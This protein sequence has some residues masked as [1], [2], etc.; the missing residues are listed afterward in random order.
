M[1]WMMLTMSGLTL[2]VIAAGYF[3]SFR[4]GAKAMATTWLLVLA[5]LALAWIEQQ[6]SLADIVS[7]RV[8]HRISSYLMIAYAA[9]IGMTFHWI[10][11]LVRDRF[12][13]KGAE[14]LR[15]RNLSG[16]SNDPE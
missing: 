2:V 5:L 10:R 16:R 7:L 8:P 15:G 6:D 3:S 12:E 11:T 1:N 13:S 4:F 9:A 14:N